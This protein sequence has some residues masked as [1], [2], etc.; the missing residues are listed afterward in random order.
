MFILFFVYLA[1][2][3]GSSFWNCCIAG[4]LTLLHVFP[5]FVAFEASLD[6]RGRRLNI[7]VG[8]I[9]VNHFVVFSRC[10]LGS[11][12]YFFCFCFF[13]CGTFFFF[14]VCCCLLLF[15][16]LPCLVPFEP[17]LD[18]CCCHLHLGVCD[19][20]VNNILTFL[21]SFATFR[22][23]VLF[24]TSFFLG[25][26]LLPSFVSFEP[27]LDLRRSSFNFGICQVDVNR[28]LFVTDSLLAFLSFV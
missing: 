12:F 23:I 24:V 26:H 2:F 20:N 3:I 25:L 9:N 4:Q 7:R 6:L 10:I 19:V 5:R 8:Q 27:G 15:Q 1:N 14:Y 22:F 18:F 13:F 21:F 17:C 28:F 11:F 16:P